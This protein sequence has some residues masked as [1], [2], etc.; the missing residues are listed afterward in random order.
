MFGT[1][2]Y[3]LFC[4]IYYYFIPQKEEGL[5][6]QSMNSFDFEE[7]NEEIYDGTPVTVSEVPM[8]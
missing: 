4:R 7:D 6:L 8:S 3:N 1:E 5:H 2:I